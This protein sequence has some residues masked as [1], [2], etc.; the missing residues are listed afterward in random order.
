MYEK[1]NTLRANCSITAFVSLGIHIVLYLAGGSSSFFAIKVITVA[2]ALTACSIKCGA[3][4]IS[5]EEP[6]ES[7]L[8]MV[9]CLVDII[10]NVMRPV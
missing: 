2:I 6:R 9:I 1:L 8:F 5:D 3:E 7:I 10:V 4:V